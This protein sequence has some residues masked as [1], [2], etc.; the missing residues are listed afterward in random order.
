MKRVVI[1]GL[2][3]LSALGS[4]H[5][6][7]WN[8]LCAGESGISSIAQVNCEH[9]RFSQGAEV[10]QYDKHV[11]FDEKRLLFLDR[12]AQFA[13]IAA[14]EAVADSG[15]TKKELAQAQTAVITG[16][17]MGGKITEDEGFY[18][19]Y[20]EQCQRSHPLIIPNAMANAG[21]SHIA[22]EFGIT[23]PTYT[24]STACASSMHAIG[25]AYW[26]VRHGLVKQAIAGGSEAPFSFGQLK[27]WE[28]MRII[29]P[30]LCRPFSKH[31]SGMILGE[32]SAILILEAMDSALARGANIYA[33]IK[34]F[35]MSADATH[36]T[37]PATLGQQQAIMSALQDASLPTSEIQHINAHGTGT[38]VN[39]RVEA[40]TLCVIFKEHIDNIWVNSTKGAHGHL[41]GATGAIEIAST[42]LAI[43]HQLIPPTLHFLEKDNEC[44]LPLVIHRVKKTFIEHALCNSFAFGGLNGILVLGA[45]G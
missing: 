40:E 36:L 3:V 2:G 29:S 35:G 20:A 34:G 37:T 10:K 13:L 30:D 41:L 9:L 32:G 42:T 44:D 24:V 12:F 16:S 5:L 1:T 25:Q 8:A 23:G 22:Y 43:K 33:E 17:C 38:L 18:R 21:A 7:F 27:A 45:S 15:L 6:S 4:N 39:D 11:H 14:R 19:L 31:R 26:L 28:G